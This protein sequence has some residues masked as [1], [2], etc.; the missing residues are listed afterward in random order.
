MTLWIGGEY[1]G[2]WLW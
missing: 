1:L 2:G